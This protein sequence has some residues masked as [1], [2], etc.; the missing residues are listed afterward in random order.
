ARRVERS[1]RRRGLVDAR[2]ALGRT[3]QD[4]GD[5]RRPRLADRREA[6]PLVT[7]PHEVLRTE[8]DSRVGRDLVVEARVH[9]ALGAHPVIVVE[10]GI[11]GE[12][13]AV[14]AGAR[15]RL[16]VGVLPLRIERRDV[17][18]GT[19]RRVV[20]VRSAVAAVRRLEPGL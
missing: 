12:A 7:V 15:L 18:V 17:V 14:D 10:D 20:F 16:A 1:E 3:L 4:L 8:E 2:L 5:D 9:G 13:L 11:N 6:L 19:A